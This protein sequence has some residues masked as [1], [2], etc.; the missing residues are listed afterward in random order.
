MIATRLSFLFGCIDDRVRY[1]QYIRLVD[2][3]YDF[4]DQ[5]IFSSFVNL[6][7]NTAMSQD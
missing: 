6:M 7:W 4:V 3:F 1:D 2:L 5:C